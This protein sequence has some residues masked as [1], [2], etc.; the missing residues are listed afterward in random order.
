MNVSIY[1]RVDGVKFAGK[2]K[3]KLLLKL[4]L[5]VKVVGLIRLDIPE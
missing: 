5:V 2:F 3:L 1:F 4:Q